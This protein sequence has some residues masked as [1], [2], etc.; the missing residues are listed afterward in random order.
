MWGELTNI[1]SSLP[2]PRREWLAVLQTDKARLV[3]QS[4]LHRVLGRTFKI[5]ATGGLELQE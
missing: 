4:A 2:S 5:E 3:L 1:Q